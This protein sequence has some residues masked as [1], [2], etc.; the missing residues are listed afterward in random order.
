M[1]FLSCLFLALSAQMSMAQ[2]DPAMLPRLAGPQANQV[3]NANTPDSVK[4]E[5]LLSNGTKL[6]GL[7]SLSKEGRYSEHVCV[8]T[9]GADADCADHSMQL[10]EV[11]KK[12]V[13]AR[14]SLVDPRRSPGDGIPGS[15]I[16][17]PKEMKL[18]PCE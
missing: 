4:F 2:S 5:V 6:Y 10:T 8:Q 7:R 1:K 14:L 15:T 17:S 11:Q 13:A 12:C 18:L 9:A 3:P 16:K